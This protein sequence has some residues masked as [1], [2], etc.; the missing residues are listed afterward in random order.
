MVHVMVD[1]FNI[2]NFFKAVLVN[3]FVSVLVA[4]PSIIISLYK[5]VYTRS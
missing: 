2:F 1:M 4:S 3:V 5:I